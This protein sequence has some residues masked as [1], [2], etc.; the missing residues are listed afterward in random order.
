MITGHDI[1]ISAI[2][3]VGNKSNGTVTYRNVDAARVMA[4]CRVIR[5][6]RPKH[7]VI[8]AGR[9]IGRQLEIH[10]NIFA[11]VPPGQAFDAR[12]GRSC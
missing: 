11:T 9:V 7:A 5:G 2:D 3:R 1:N 6:I 8:M 12:C 10:G 4:T